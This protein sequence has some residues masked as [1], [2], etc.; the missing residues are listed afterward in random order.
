MLS[1]GQKH[2]RLLGNYSN[3]NDVATLFPFIALILFGLD[4]NDA[5][6]II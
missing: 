6:N 4:I 3:V 5:N 1:A 2:L